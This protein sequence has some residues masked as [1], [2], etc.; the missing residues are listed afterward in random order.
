MKANGQWIKCAV[1]GK[2]IYRTPA[3]LKPLNCCSRECFKQIS[4]PRMTIM[5]EALNPN[6]MTEVIKE[7]IRNSRL[8]PAEKRKSYTKYHGTHEHRI[9]AE[10]MLGRP[11][12]IGEVVH[13]IDRNKQNNSPSN[14]MIFESQAEHAKWHKEHDKGGDAE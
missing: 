6:R 7:K 4:S 10:Q 13:H 5:N 11:L 3:T 14:L 12:K 8:I 9:V 2:S 1:C